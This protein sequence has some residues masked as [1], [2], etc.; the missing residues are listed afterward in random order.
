MNLPSIWEEALA[1]GR[2]WKQFQLLSNK[3]DE[4][5]SFSIKSYNDL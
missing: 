1:S 5:K 3:F 2:A 4:L